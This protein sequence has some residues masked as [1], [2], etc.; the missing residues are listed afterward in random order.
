MNNLDFIPLYFPNSLNVFLLL[1][2]MC[3]LFSYLAPH[4]DFFLFYK[5]INL[6][7][8]AVVNA[9]AASVGFSVTCRTARTATG[10]A[11]ATSA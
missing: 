1:F 8:T 11:V 4:V 5:C 7:L 3:A 9:T 10:T 6:V 2:F